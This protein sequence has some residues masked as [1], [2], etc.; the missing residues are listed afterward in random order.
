MV[1]DHRAMPELSGYSWGEVIAVN[2][3]AAD[4]AAYALE[5]WRNSPTH[6]AVL[7]WADLRFIGC[8]ETVAVQPRSAEDP[9]LAEKHY[10]VCLLTDRGYVPSGATIPDTA[11]PPPWIPVLALLLLGLAAAR[12]TRHGRAHDPHRAAGGPDPPA[13]PPPGQDGAPAPV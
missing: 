11:L 10:F 6:W 4:P 12:L 13:A 5:G 8:G 9:S 7:T 3:W 2:W 1:F